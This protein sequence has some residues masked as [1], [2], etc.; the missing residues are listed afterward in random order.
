MNGSPE[1]QRLDKWLWHARTVK[2][3]SLAQKLVT[4]GKV[5]IDSERTVSASAKLRIGQVL[6]ITLD[7]EIRILRVCGFS[8][9]RGPYTLA[10]QLYEDLS[11]PKPDRL[12]SSPSTD[13]KRVEKRPSRNDR[14]AAILI[15]QESHMKDF[16]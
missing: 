12:K 8:D 11:P 6:T 7:R 13:G 4:S 1:T 14:R 2:T 16:G 5:R 3:R 15:K 9:R 10:S